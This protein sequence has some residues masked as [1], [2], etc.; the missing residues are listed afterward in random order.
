MA[1]YFF[2]YG[3]MKAWSSCIAWL[4]D[5]EDEC[6]AEEIKSHREQR[7]SHGLSRIPDKEE[8]RVPRRDEEVA[9]SGRRWGAFR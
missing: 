2:K 6:A 3:T 5:D 1:Q 8:S 9:V 4:S 7:V